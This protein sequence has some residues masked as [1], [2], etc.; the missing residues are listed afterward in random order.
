MIEAGGGSGLKQDGL[1]GQT[2]QSLSTLRLIVSDDRMSALI[3]P[4]DEMLS[5]L[6]IHLLKELLN[7]AGIRHGVVDDLVLSDFLSEASQRERP[8]EVARGTPPDP[9]KQSRI[10]YCFNTD[11]LVVGKEDESGRIDFKNRGEIPQV[12]TGDLLAEI[13]PGV[14]GRPGVDVYGM[15]VPPPAH[16]PVKLLYGKGTYC[17]P[18]GLKVYSQIDG[19]PELTSEDRICVSPDLV[20]TGD[21]GYATGH[22][23][24]EGN[25][26]VRGAVLEGFHVR[27]HNLRAEEI[28]RADIAV[29]GDVTVSGGIIGS[30]VQADGVLKCKH[31][32]TS[33]IE[34]IGD[35]K[36]ET[37]IF[38][39]DVKTNGS[40]IVSNGRILS[41]AIS[42][43][44]G[45]K[46]VDVG[47]DSSEPCELLVGV[48]GFLS[49]VVDKLNAEIDSVKESIKTLEADLDEM[50][51]ES[52]KLE[53]EIGELAQEEDSNRLK[54]SE[55]Q[56]K[57]KAASGAG[58]MNGHLV[59]KAKDL[60]RMLEQKV[61][62]AGKSIEE[63]FKRQ[64]E[65]EEGIE[66][67]KSEIQKAAGHIDDLK[68]KIDKENEK[69]QG[70]KGSPSVKVA[71]VIYSG[72]VIRGPKS[73]IKLKDDCRN[74]TIKEMEVERENQRLEWSMEILGR[75]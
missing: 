15:E 4:E 33:T 26:E 27:A 6:D 18:D 60:H 28:N 29:G 11:P 45:I 5:G 10:R 36:V 68:E 57:I 9:G 59:Q 69:A 37:T 12:K 24:F 21:V 74:K 61:E 38:D 8:W 44:M 65:L 32:H 16:P 20:I 50:K 67:R 58:D 7:K 31:I 52:E 13:I 43:K 66:R 1:N 34:V 48:D 46:A 41:S 39:S 17:H 53:T 30:R 49:K 64:E 19:R 72:T 40:C 62:Q 42:A 14:P 23:S 51:K 75:H 55:I 35:I 25:V 54:A 3:D 22:V 71:N 63:K 70:E 56:E 2:V 73:I 47:S